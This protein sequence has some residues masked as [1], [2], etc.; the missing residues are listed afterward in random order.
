[1]LADWFLLKINPRKRVEAN[2][3]PKPFPWTKDSD[4]IIAAVRPGTKL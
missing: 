4:K 1:V 2:E 3:N